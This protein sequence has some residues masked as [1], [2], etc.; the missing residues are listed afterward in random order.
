M[1]NII[2][3]DGFSGCFRCGFVWRA[4]NPDVA[5]CARCKSLLW[6]SPV[7]RPVRRGSGLGIHEIVEPKRE[8]LE[9]ALMQAK[10]RNP[11]VFGSIARRAGTR[12]SDLDLLIDFEPEASLFDQVGLSIELEKLFRRRVDV[13]DP[14]GLHWL[15]RPQVL[16]EAVPI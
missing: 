6:D 9:V 1:S 5:R 14:G 12:R 4:R 16:F 15:I 11:R 10:A 8:A 3:P 7:I 2:G 13:V